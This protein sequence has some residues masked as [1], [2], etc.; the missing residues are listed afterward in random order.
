MPTG[1]GLASI[2]GRGPIKPRKS[3][4]AADSRDAAAVIEQPTPIEALEKEAAMYAR[5][6]QDDASVN[7]SPALQQPVSA[8]E[9]SQPSNRAAAS[10]A[11]NVLDKRPRAGLMPQL[12]TPGASKEVV[13]GAEK[14]QRQQ[15]PAPQQEPAVAHQQQQQHPAAPPRSAP[16]GGLSG[17]FGRPAPKLR[18]S[19]PT[20]ASEPPATLPTLPAGLPPVESPFGAPFRPSA[21]PDG[22]VSSTQLPRMPRA[23]RAPRA[24]R[25]SDPTTGSRPLSATYSGGAAYAPTPDAPARPPA[26][27]AAAFGGSNGS[28]GG[29]NSGGASGGSGNSGGLMGVFGRP[30]NRAPRAP[31][32]PR[33]ETMGS[34][35]V[36]PTPPV[37]AA[38]EP[39]QGAWSTRPPG[40]AAPGG[41]M[42]AFGASNRAPRAPRAPRSKPPPEDTN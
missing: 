27:A 22:N 29:S 6:T 10:F 2:F 20:P 1:G 40:G 30:T 26:A 39:P 28:G 36:T 16:G 38:P 42:C 23:G 4:P 34:P 9:H 7:S 17:M 14:Q 11:T 12:R 24:A 18:A 13:S 8:R 19:V 32:V 35:R 3:Q 37:G 31:R 33:P 5:N 21:E 15:Q 25:A 41:L